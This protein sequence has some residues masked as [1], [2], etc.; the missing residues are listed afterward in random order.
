MSNAVNK[1]LYSYRKVVTTNTKRSAP[2]TKEINNG[3]VASQETRHTFVQQ[4]LGEDIPDD[5]VMQY[6]LIL[7]KQTG[8]GAMIDNDDDIWNLPSLSKF[9]EAEEREIQDTLYR[10]DILVDEG[11]HVCKR[12]Q[13]KRIKLVS[14]QE[15]GR[16]EGETVRALCLKCG[17]RWKQ[18]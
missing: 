9:K 3:V 11:V 5:P 7:A 1:K 18:D 17:F 10:N 15:R 14:R 16:D 2:K 6:E 4:Q 8:S 13:C 12:C